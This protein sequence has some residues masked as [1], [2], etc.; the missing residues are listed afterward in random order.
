M[1]EMGGWP[2]LEGNDWNSKKDFK[3]IDIILKR[4]KIGFSI[5]TI[6]IF[7]VDVNV[8]NSSQWMIWLDQPILPVPQEY[9]LQGLN[10]SDVQAFLQYAIDLAVLLG[11][12]KTTAKKEMTEVVGF[13]IDIFNAQEE[14]RFVHHIH[15][16]MNLTQLYELAPL[17]NW[18]NVINKILPDTIE[19]DD[20]E[21]VN[22]GDVRYFGNLTNLLK[23]TPE[24]V[25]ANYLML[26]GVIQAASF[27]SKDIRNLDLK[28]LRTLSGRVTHLPRWEQCIA[29]VSRSLSYAVSNLYVKHYLQNGSKEK[30]EILVRYLR[31]SFDDMLKGLEWMDDETKKQALKKERAINSYIGYPEELLH[32]ENIIK[33]IMFQI[34]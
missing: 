27:L 19:V 29:M 33:L 28:F 31:N 16:V 13:M 24:R 17:F 34:M 18:T 4:R 12:N 21:L 10:E 14:R 22:V 6:F 8:Q 2:V 32:D 1:K 30:V 11:A 25:V 20:S 3:W 5:N 7:D 23:R 9:L 15:N 26:R